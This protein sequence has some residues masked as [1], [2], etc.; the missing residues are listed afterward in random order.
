MTDRQALKRQYRDVETRAGVYAI[1]NTVD[2]RALVAGSRNA[3][4]ALNRHRFQLRYGSHPD[5]RLAEDFARH[6]ES[7][8]VFEVL[9]MVKPNGDPAFDPIAELEALVALWRDEIP[10]EGEQG[11]DVKGFRR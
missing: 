4:A 5:A 9:D 6:G 3:E 7:A 8:F 10:C 11:Y 1:R 2:R